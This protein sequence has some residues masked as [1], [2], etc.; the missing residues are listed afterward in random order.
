MCFQVNTLNSS[1]V[2]FLP[3]C[4][5]SI[6]PPSWPKSQWAMIN[7]YNALNTTGLGWSD[8]YFFHWSHDTKGNA[9][10]SQDPPPPQSLVSLPPLLGLLLFF[11]KKGFICVRL[12]VQFQK[13]EDEQTAHPYKV[14]L[15]CCKQL[16]P[17]L[18][19]VG[20]LYIFLFQ[21]KKRA[22]CQ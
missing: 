15:C 17:C 4:L 16:P 22:L 8:S 10:H 3:F 14:L 2:C 6:L 1:T 21:L 7:D 13:R 20:L 12:D 9:N 19:K 5:V 18:M 11:L